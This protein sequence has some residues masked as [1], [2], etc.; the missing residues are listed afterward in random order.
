[1]KEHDIFISYK[2]DDF[3]VASWL[4]SV[5]ETN[6]ISCWMAPADIPG[7][8][9]YAREIPNAIEQCKVLV[10]VIS[11]RTQ[12]SIW[13]PKELD[14][15]INKGK[16]IMPFMVDNISLKDDF[17]FYLSNVQRY[18][19]YESKTSAVEKM[20]SEIRA[21]LG[22]KSDGPS[23]V[24]GAPQAVGTAAES[25]TARA[26]S[27]A[28]K[29]PLR[30]ILPVLLLI[31]AAAAAYFAGL[32]GRPETPSR[33]ETEE[34]AAET[35][36]QPPMHITLYAPEDMTVREFGSAQATLKERLDILTGGKEYQW[37]AVEDQIDLMIPAAAF[38]ELPPESALRCYLT[39][40]IELYLVDL[41]DKTRYVHIQRDDIEKITLL[42][43]T[44]AGVDPA[45]YGI[46]TP[47][48]Q[49]IELML[50]DD[51]IAAH[52]E[53]KSWGKPVFAQ[54]V[55]KF[56]SMW[57]YFAT[58]PGADFKTNYVINNDVGGF[59]SELTVYNLT[60]E[61]LPKAFS[62]IVD[63]STSVAWQEPSGTAQPGRNQCAM[64]AAKPGS[65]IFTLQAGTYTAGHKMDAEST[66]KA[67][68]DAIGAPYA[69][70]TVEDIDGGLRFAVMMPA[71]RSGLPIMELLRQ[72]YSFSLRAGLM[73]TSLS[74]SALKLSARPDES[75]FTLSLSASNETQTERLKRFGSAAVQEDAPIYLYADKYPIFTVQREELQKT[76]KLHI[77]GLCDLK[78]NR[79]VSRPL[80]DDTQWLADMTQ[81]LLEYPSLPISLRLDTYQ[82]DA[83]A[84]GN[85]QTEQDFLIPW[86]YDRDAL[87]ESLKSVCPDA[88][89]YFK[90][91]DISVMLNLPIDDSFP[92]KA[93]EVAMQIYQ[94]IDF[95]RIDADH[96]GVYLVNEDDAA[97]ERARIFFTK[98][99]KE[100][101]SLDSEIQ[102][103][104]IYT[105]GILKNGRLTPYGKQFAQTIQD[106]AFYQN[107]T[108]EITTWNIK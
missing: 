23:S 70:G 67:R 52:P 36:V 97:N 98:N 58:I 8:S 82:L 13:V 101:Y 4:R 18:S 28:K 88:R 95:E 31:L 34:T 73:K 93:P 102:K 68:L 65:V 47:S 6:G 64:E 25:K 74:F 10:V 62:F 79:I 66:L 103:G 14:T 57:F 20:I 59:Y 54:D 44:I 84:N 94:A 56:S 12:E 49:Y 22:A 72:S 100:T 1:M 105:Y 17:N 96:L 86:S 41:S 90:D 76:G 43:G 75:G 15:A 106:M 30:I 80:D 29:K 92:R 19:A 69:F 45:D 33:P 42:N 48:Y 104:Y 108:N 83:D 24:T 99:P 89:I 81:S 91:A 16:T 37:K 71:Q 21:I 46:N 51:F 27:A 9:N 2:S 26:P 11:S 61:P 38:A 60:H 53:I 107:L 7:G 40:P 5:L 63:L 35:A 77:T 32:F 85:L 78:N 55:E 87:A 39:R 50:K 3:E